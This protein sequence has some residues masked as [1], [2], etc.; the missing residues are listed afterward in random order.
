MTMDNTNSDETRI[1]TY[2]KLSNAY[3]Q[4][5]WADMDYHNSSTL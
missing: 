3:R 2:H 1:P 5:V 4:I